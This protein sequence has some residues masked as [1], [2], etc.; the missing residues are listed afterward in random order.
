MVEL[1]KSLEAIQDLLQ[2]IY[3]ITANQTTILLEQ[4]K[5]LEEEEEAL[6]MLEKM[7]D[8]K[9]ELIGLVEKQEL[10]FE[11]L[12]AQY[13]SQITNAD[14]IKLFKHHVANILTKKKEIK[15]A[16]QANVAI[17]QGRAHRRNKQVELPKNA[18][19]V[20]QAYQR[21]KK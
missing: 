19:Q 2:Q 8:Y 1:L 17:M 21:M 5:S 7:V 20:V 3:S 6:S 4:G 12:Y 14:D 9:E 15:E 18:Q 11:N 16:E 10:D 13:K